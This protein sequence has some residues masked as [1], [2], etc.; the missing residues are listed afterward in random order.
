MHPNYNFEN[1]ISKMWGTAAMDYRK[2][3][4]ILL[5][6][7]KLITQKEY[8][9]IMWQACNLP[10]GSIIR[11]ELLKTLKE[12]EMEQKIKGLHCNQLKINL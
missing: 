3:A 9:I 4:D 5:S 10:T 1:E 7:Y 2:L 11:T 12:L 6:K 8:D